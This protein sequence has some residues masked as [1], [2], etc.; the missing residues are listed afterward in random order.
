M[1]V[2]ITFDQEGAGSNDLNRLHSMFLRFGWQNLGGSTY[3]Y[4][5][6][7][8][9][10]QPE[11][12]LNHVVPALMLLRSYFTSFDRPLLRF[13]LDAHT[14]TAIDRES[15]VGAAPRNSGGILCDT[16]KREFGESN[17]LNWLDSIKFPYPATRRT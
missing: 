12:W 2:V 4:P 16:G 6:L 3:R 7:A 1:P 17:L 11:D 10:E 8:C 15:G 14:S 9:S 5:Q 13:T